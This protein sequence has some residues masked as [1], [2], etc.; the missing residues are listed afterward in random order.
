MGPKHK[1][2]TEDHAFE[3]SNVMHWLGRILHKPC[4]CLQEWSS[5]RMVSDGAQDNSAITGNAIYNACNEFTKGNWMMVS[6]KRFVVIAFVAR[7]IH[8]E[9][10][11]EEARWVRHQ[12]CIPPLIPQSVDFLPPDDNFLIRFHWFGTFDLFICLAATWGFDLVSRDNCLCV[13][14]A[15]ISSSFHLCF[16]RGYAFWACCIRATAHMGPLRWAQTESMVLQ[17]IALSYK[18]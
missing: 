15:F 4:C 7:A 1:R 11:R 13:A 8:R 6:I 16:R 14:D 18:A 12:L 2:M 10:A 5:L 9:K 3:H 17:G